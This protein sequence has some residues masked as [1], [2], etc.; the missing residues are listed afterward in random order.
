MVDLL[1]DF[2]SRGWSGSA[3]TVGPWR[4]I[5]CDTMG[6]SWTRGSGEY[7][8][9]LCAPED[10]QANLVL[11]DPERKLDPKNTTGPYYGQIDVGADLRLRFGGRQVFIGRIQTLAH[12]FQFFGSDTVAIANMQVTGHQ[13]KLA[14]IPA[15]A[16]SL[17]GFGTALWPD[18]ITY[19]RVNR[20]L[21]ACE[22]PAAD[23]D[24]E[25]GGQMILDFGNTAATT[26]GSAWDVLVRTMV[27]EIGSVELTPAGV[28]RTRNR[29]TVWNTTPAATLHLGCCAHAGV[30]PIFEGSF[31]TLKD[32]VRNHVKITVEANDVY[33]PVEDAASKAKYGLRKYDVGIGETIIYF[34]A[35]TDWVN[36]FLP[37]MKDPLR[38]WRLTMRPQTQAQIDALETVFLYTSRVHVVIDDVGG[39]LIDLQLRPVGVEWSVDPDGSTCVMV[40]GG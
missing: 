2:R 17:D 37:R 39:D 22:V 35:A 12:E 33:G 34:N 14:L 36:Y 13:G 4:A 26:A 40:L 5:E 3:E 7:R 20:I 23:R 19:T 31:A 38:S 6:V 18:E 8:G 1:I 27:A 21:D 28:V 10:G 30:I 15:L 29:N 25:A 32:T 16:L 11:W 9:L 24:I